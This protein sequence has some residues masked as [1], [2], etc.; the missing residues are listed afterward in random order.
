MYTCR[1]IEAMLSN[2]TLIT[3]GGGGLEKNGGASCAHCKNFNIHEI[4]I[5]RACTIASASKA[6][7]EFLGLAG[8]SVERQEAA[9]G[10]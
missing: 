8:H 2:M 10:W 4:A 3:R 9:I 1:R 7:F 6:L 5:F